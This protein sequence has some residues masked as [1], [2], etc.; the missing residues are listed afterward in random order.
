MDSFSKAKRLFIVPMKRFNITRSFVEK[1]VPEI[2]P[3]YYHENLGLCNV[4]RITS[5]INFCFEVCIQ[6][7]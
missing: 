2:T 7:Y 6:V 3:L 1:P 5:G 4:E